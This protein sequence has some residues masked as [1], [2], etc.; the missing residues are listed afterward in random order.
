ML[1]SS[2]GPHAS[3]VNVNLDAC[4]C[5]CTGSQCFL[6]IVSLSDINSFLR[7]WVLITVD[8]SKFNMMIWEAPLYCSEP[9]ATLEVNSSKLSATADSM[10]RFLLLMLLRLDT[11]FLG[12]R[13]RL[14]ILVHLLWN[15]KHTV[16]GLFQ[17]MSQTYNV[18]TYIHTLCWSNPA[19]TL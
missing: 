17:R 4:F 7:L 10:V 1:P 3:E 15:K 18:R 2:G 14:Q 6:E 12:S 9:N 13:A 19:C 8:W 5:S 16:N 11:I